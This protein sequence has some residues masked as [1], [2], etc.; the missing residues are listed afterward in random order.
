MMGLNTDNSAAG[1]SSYTAATDHST[2]AAIGKTYAHEFAASTDTDKRPDRTSDGHVS[3]GQYARDSEGLADAT[4]HEALQIDF[5]HPLENWLGRRPF[6]WLL[7]L[8]SRPGRDGVTALERILDTY[9]DPGVSFWRRLKYWPIHLFID[10]MR[11]KTDVVT[12]R[13]KL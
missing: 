13:E 12:F 10:R 9:H 6:R 3:S 8:I 5:H 7:R 1:D 11:G 4:A 2:A